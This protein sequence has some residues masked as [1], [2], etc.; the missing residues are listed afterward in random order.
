M[1]N[2]EKFWAVRFHLCFRRFILMAVRFGGHSKGSYNSSRDS[3]GPELRLSA[4]RETKFQNCDWGQNSSRPFSY[5]PGLP[6]VVHCPPDGCCSVTTPMGQQVGGSEQ[7]MWPHPS[8]PLSGATRSPRLG[9]VWF[10]LFRPYYKLF[11]GHFARH[12]LAFSAGLLPTSPHPP[13]HPLIIPLGF[14][15]FFS[16]FLL[17]CQLI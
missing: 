12:V 2:Y 6:S 5:L 11:F 15:K 9:G 3:Y 1:R 17:P 4:C 13:P 8:P 10:Q 14:Y 16:F 7:A